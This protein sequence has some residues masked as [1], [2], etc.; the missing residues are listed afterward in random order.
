[1]LISLF[2]FQVLGAY[3]II[4]VCLMQMSSDLSSVNRDL[5]LLLHFESTFFFLKKKNLKNVLM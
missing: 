3:G 1:V 4:F 5:C 2:F